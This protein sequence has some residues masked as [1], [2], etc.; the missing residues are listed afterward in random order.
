MIVD[1]SAVVAILRDEPES[2]RF[3]GVIAAAA[4]PKMSVVNYVEAG[5]V[6][7][8][9]K[10]PAISRQLD[11]LIRVAGVE[12]RPVTPEQGRLAREAYRD[13]GRGTGHPAKLNFGD[14]FAYALAKETGEPLLFKGTDFSETDLTPAV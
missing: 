2:E 6:A 1:T 10:S 5:V 7:D 9:A 3:S 4:Q 14:C 8:A 11:E 12:I 13:F